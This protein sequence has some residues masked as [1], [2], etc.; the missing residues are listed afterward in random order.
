MDNDHSE[1]RIL[2]CIKNISENELKKPKQEKHTIFSILKSVFFEL[3]CPKDRYK[4]MA[5]DPQR[6]ISLL[7]PSKQRGRGTISN[8]L[9]PQGISK[10]Q[11]G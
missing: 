5:A 1:L 9:L 6:I 3:T 2:N 8:S 7:K 4:S 10:T 11:F